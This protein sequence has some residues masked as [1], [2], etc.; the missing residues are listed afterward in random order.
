MRRMMCV[1]IIVGLGGEKTL[2]IIAWGPWWV[3]PVRAGL[4]G[5]EGE[6]DLSGARLG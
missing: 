2:C 1:W 5:Q 6:I 3:P 4:S